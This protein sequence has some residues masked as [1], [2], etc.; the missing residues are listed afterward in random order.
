MNDIRIVNIAPAGPVSKHADSLSWQG[1]YRVPVV[2][3]LE[4]GRRI[5]TGQRFRLKRDAVAELASLPKPPR[6]SMRAIFE[7]SG[8]FFGTST[9]FQFGQP[10]N[11]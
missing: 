7:E 10:A 4:D 11:H 1:A 9:S 8:A 2:Y 6:H 5:E 3:V